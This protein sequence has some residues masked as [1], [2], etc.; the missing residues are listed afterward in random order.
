MR[1]R[2]ILH[3]AFGCYLVQSVFGIAA[4]NSEGKLY[5]PR[6]CAEDH[7]IEDLG[8]LPSLEHWIRNM[9]LQPWMGGAT[10]A[11]H[12]RS[13]KT[14]AGTVDPAENAVRDALRELGLSTGSPGAGLLQLERVD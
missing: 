3:N 4:R 8:F 7:I 14:R 2:A 9:T 12:M 13:G 10:R 5:S 11:Q 1:H 6:D